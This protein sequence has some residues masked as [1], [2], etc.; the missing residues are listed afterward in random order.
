MPP[1]H[2]SS[3]VSPQMYDTLTPGNARVALSLFGYVVCHTGRHVSVHIATDDQCVFERFDARMLAPQ[4]ARPS[5]CWCAQPGT[6]PEGVRS[7][8]LG[9][10]ATTTDV[11]HRR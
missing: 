1:W 6:A 9:A 5:A 3:G 2:T 7:N 11:I 10:T 8:A 4:G